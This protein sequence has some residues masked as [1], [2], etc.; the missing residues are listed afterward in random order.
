MMLPQAGPR[1][2]GVVAVVAVL[3]G[4]YLSAHHSFRWLSGAGLTEH[5]QGFALGVALVIGG[6]LLWRSRHRE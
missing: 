1:G 4:G 3:L 6:I 2:R 5:E